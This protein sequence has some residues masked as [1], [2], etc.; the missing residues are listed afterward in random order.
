M[1]KKLIWLSIIFGSFVFSLPMIRSGIIY[2]F[3]MG[4]WGPNAHDG[5]WHIAL[6]KQLKLNVPPLNPIF[7][8]KILTHYHWGFNLLSAWLDKLIPLSTVNVYFQL[9]PILVSISIG[10]L[11]YLLV[12]RL[13]SKKDSALFFVFLNFFAGSFGW[14]VSLAKTGE[15]G[16]ES[17]FWSM[18][19]ISTLIN[20]PF[21]LSLVILFVILILWQSK[22]SEQRLIWAAIIGSLIGFLSFVKI[23]AGILAGLGFSFYCFYKFIIKELNVFDFVI[24]IVAALVS[25]FF[26]AIMGIFG[27]P[28]SLIFRPLWFPHT[29]IES[30]DKLYLPKLAVLRQNLWHQAFSLKLPILILIEFCLVVL[31]LIGN[32]GTRVFGYIDLFK[33]KINEDN[34]DFNLLILFIQFFGILLPLIFIQKGTAWN[35]IQFFYYVQIFANFYLAQ[36]LSKLWRKKR[37]FLLSLVLLLTIPTTYSTLKNYLGN[38]P[39]AALPPTEYHALKELESK[40]GN[41]V[42][43]YPFSP[44]AKD[45]LSTPIPLYLY[46][47]TAYVSAISGKTSYIED[48]INLEITGYP[49]LKRKENSQKFF[50]TDELF[51][52]RGF[53]LNNQIDYI[54]LVDDQNINLKPDD[55]GLKMIFDQENVRIYQ[56]LK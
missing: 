20:P 16:G 51:W 46:E 12:Y 50:S 56:V 35:T 28:S 23:Y 22:K 54:Y 4:F 47:T 48:E 30:L 13:T 6:I 26:L 36:Y 42:L 15:I 32:L 43:T 5:I 41:V 45:N 9:I 17:L 19:S 33:K 25:L 7:S 1:K 11:S 8:G 53:L 10:C 55:L 37:F 39:P 2:D 31:F 49:W 14:V 27:R 40:S 29:L 24:P 21:A 44:S 52:A 38:P 34:S 18:Q 3:G